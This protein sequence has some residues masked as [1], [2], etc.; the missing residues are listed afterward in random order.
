[1]I[2][3]LLD[4]LKDLFSAVSTSRALLAGFIAMRL[5]VLKA[6]IWNALGE[7]I[8]EAVTIT[9]IPQE[10]IAGY[11]PNG[12]SQ[13]PPPGLRRWIEKQKR[14]WK[15]YKDKPHYVPHVDAY[16]LVG[17]HCH[18]RL[19]PPEANVTRK[20]LLQ[21][22]LLSCLVLRPYCLSYSEHAD[23]V[24]LY[25]FDRDTP[26]ISTSK[27]DRISH[28][29]GLTDKEIHDLNRAVRYIRAVYDDECGAIVSRASKE[30]AEFPNPDDPTH[31]ALARFLGDARRRDF[32]EFLEGQH[33]RSVFKNQSRILGEE[34]E[35]Y[36]S[37]RECVCFGATFFNEMQ[38]ATDDVERQLQMIKAVS[39]LSI[40]WDGRSGLRVDFKNHY[41]QDGVYRKFSDLLITVGLVTE[42]PRVKLPR[43]DPRG[44]P[45]PPGEFDDQ[46]SWSVVAGSANR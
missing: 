18:A 34:L 25:R 44:G 15:M 23:F 21:L 10:M 31:M 41:H 13:D 45:C 37:L 4:K 27:G 42:E 3:G 40:D 43:W 19:D 16:R 29:Q 46:G 6:V 17:K 11:E 12:A 24:K 5:E 9:S 7:G 36:F 26:R 32:N 8:R 14:L 20:S 30:A 35:K 28:G 39:P 2:L 33:P 38:K 1:M 22:E